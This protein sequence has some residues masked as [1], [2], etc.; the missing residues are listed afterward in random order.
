MEPPTT[1]LGGSRRTDADSSRGAS[2]RTGGRAGGRRSAAGRGGGGRSAEDL[3]YDVLRGEIEHGLE[4]GTP[5]RLSTIAGRLGV[6]TMPVRAA[7]KRLEGDRLVRQLA[8]RGTVVA[9]LELDDIEEIQA[10]RWGIEG[11]AARLGTEAV[12][13]DDIARMQDHLERIRDAAARHDPDAYLAATYDLEDTCYA[14]AD[15]PRLLAT[16]RHYRWAALRY[17]RVVIGAH[18]QLEVPPAERF[19]DAAAARD[20]S[21]TEQLIQGQIARLFALIADRMAAGPPWPGAPR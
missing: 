18:P 21:L 19:M 14:A 6:S 16:V 11:L 12:G 3:V 4:P 20:G 10:I 5:L 7:L 9:P 15:R 13:P 1:S 8:R 2:E 17:V